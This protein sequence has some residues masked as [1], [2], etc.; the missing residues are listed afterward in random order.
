MIVRMSVSRIVGKMSVVKSVVIDMLVF[1]VMVMSMM[2]GGMVL[3]II[4]VVVS[5][6]RSLFFGMLWWCIFGNRIGV[7][8]VMLVVFE[9]E[10]LEMSIMVFRSI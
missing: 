8:V 7:M 4:L 2:E 9:F 5:S 6:E 1:D 3:F 10:M